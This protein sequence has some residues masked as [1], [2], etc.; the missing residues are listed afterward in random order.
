MC[1]NKLHFCQYL[2]IVLFI[3]LFSHLPTTPLNRILMIGIFVHLL[4]LIKNVLYN[5]K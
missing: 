3:Y 2:D 1:N 4:Q 5:E